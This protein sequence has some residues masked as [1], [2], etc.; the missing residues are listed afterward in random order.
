MELWVWI[1]LA[2]VVIGVALAAWFGWQRQRSRGLH[3]RFGPE[4]ERTLEERGDRREAEAELAAR[5][6]RHADLD[7][8]PLDPETRER[9]AAEW[10]DTQAAF[11]DRPP[12]A[13]HR[14][15][16]LVA[17]LMR[18]RGYPV[19]DF[20]QRAADISVDHPGVVDNYRSAHTI[21]LASD[22]NE[23][24]TEDLRKSMVYYRSLFNELLVE[25]HPSEEARG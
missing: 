1:V 15:D 14:A 5:E 17:G 3:E 10:R 24:S 11:V 23:A 2:V 21:A 22:R 25:E 13:V 20:D 6:K 18:E 19:E 4:Y 16:E 9:Y 8:R 7:I 12:E